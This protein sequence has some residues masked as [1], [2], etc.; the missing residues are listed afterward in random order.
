MPYGYIEDDV[1]SDV[2]FRVWGATV[3]ELFRDAVDAAMNLMVDPL[4]AIVTA[5]MR[6]VATYSGG[7]PGIPGPN[8]R[9][10]PLR[11][12]KSERRSPSTT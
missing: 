4:T 10:A 1:T 9:V 8:A 11:W 5:V 6:P 7:R 12:I 2:T 3:E